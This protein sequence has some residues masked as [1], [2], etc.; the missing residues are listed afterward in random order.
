MCLEEM[1]DATLMC[2]TQKYRYTRHVRSASQFATKKTGRVNKY[3][4]AAAQSCS[5]S[6]FS[7]P[8]QNQF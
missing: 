8:K 7:V 3:G 6:L 4:D 2:C 1:A 5:H